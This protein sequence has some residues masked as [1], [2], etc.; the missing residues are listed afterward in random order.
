MGWRGLRARAS[1]RTAN[2]LVT[3]P[4]ILVNRFSHTRTTL[5]YSIENTALAQR[6]RYKV[7]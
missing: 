4:Y 3:S 1:S 6:R 2:V 5:V 7:R